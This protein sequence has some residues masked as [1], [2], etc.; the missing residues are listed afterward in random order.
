MIYLRQHSDKN[1][2]RP[3]SY[4]YQPNLLF[5]H[6]AQATQKC[7]FPRKIPLQR[8]TGKNPVT[9]FLISLGY[10]LKVWTPMRHS[11]AINA[12]PHQA[13][14]LV[15]SIVAIT[16]SIISADFDLCIIRNTNSWLFCSSIQL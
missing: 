2:F 1:Y 13:I 12:T 9:F 15:K 4:N 3:L 8:K 14:L 5:Q 7:Y 10:F 6:Q 11:F 16:Y